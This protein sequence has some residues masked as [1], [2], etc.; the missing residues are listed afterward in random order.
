MVLVGDHL[1]LFKTWDFECRLWR[2]QT[3][4]VGDFYVSI[5]RYQGIT[6]NIYDGDL[7][8]TLIKVWKKYIFLNHQLT[9]DHTWAPRPM[10]WNSHRA[11]ESVRLS[12]C[13]AAYCQHR[14]R[15]RSQYDN[16][17]WITIITTWP[18][19]CCQSKLHK[20]YLAQNRIGV[21]PERDNARLW[22]PF[23]IK[24][25]I[26]RSALDLSLTLA[27]DPHN[28]PGEDSFNPWTGFHEDCELWARPWYS[29]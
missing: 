19:R 20:I 2:I 28:M 27:S 8:W 25:F 3:E 18:H 13:E 26:A 29:N 14:A 16:P 23:Y 21:S 10:I 1:V 6:I 4:W 15:N 9:F 12:D 22:S 7:F 5:I 24:S 11:W 17:A